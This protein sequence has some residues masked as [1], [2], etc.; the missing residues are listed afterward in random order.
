MRGL[1][2][3]NVDLRGSR[4]PR[5]ITSRIRAA[6]VGGRKNAATASRF[7]TASSAS[8]ASGVNRSCSSTS[9]RT[10][11]WSAQTV[12]GVPA[13]SAMRW[14]SSPSSSGRGAV[15]EL[16]V[17]HGLQDLGQVADPGPARLVRTPGLDPVEREHRRLLHRG[18]RDEHHHAVPGTRP[19]LGAH[20]VPVAQGHRVPVMAVGDHQGLGREPGRDLGVRLGH[21][22]RVLDAG[23]VGRGRRGAVRHRIVQERGERF[24][25]APEHR[26][27]ARQVRPDRPH[28][29]E[30]VLDRPGHRPFVR[31]DRAAPVLELDR[32]DQSA[33]RAP[34]PVQREPHLVRVERRALGRDERHRSIATSRARR[35]PAYTCRPPRRRRCRPVR[36]R[37]GSRCTGSRPGSAAAHRRR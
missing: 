32:A 9:P 15:D 18:V 14:T 34:P 23:L 25:R 5:S 35:P 20:L 26:V 12:G 10:R 6:S 30:A 37:G 16:L 31:H 3:K 11:S 17:A 29:P 4:S 22:E 8:T 28:Q 7:R 19:V 2:Q 24:A 27:D 36:G 21:P 33:D 1:G 13:T